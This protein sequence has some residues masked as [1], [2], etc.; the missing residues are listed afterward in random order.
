MDRV[1]AVALARLAAINPLI[2]LRELSLDFPEDVPLVVDLDGTLLS[3][4]LLLETWLLYLRTNPEKL[5]TPFLWL[6]R[7]KAFLKD[8]LARE[9]ALDV[10]ALPYNPEIVALLTA[11]RAR[12]RQVILAT[13]SHHALAERIAQH[14]GIFDGVIA[15]DRTRNLSAQSK[16]DA[17]VAR[18]GAGGFDYAGNSR[19]DLPVWEAARQAI[20]VNPEPGVEK[21][22]RELGNVSAI[23]DSKRTSVGDWARALRCHQWLKNLLIFVPLLAAHRVTE[24]D[25]LADGLL[26]FLAFGLCASTVYILNDLLDLG[27][28]RHH[29]TKCHRPFA[30]GV[31]SIKAGVTLLPLLLATAF[32]V[33]LMWLPPAFSVVLALYFGLTTAYSLILK[34]QML[35]DVIALASL[36]TLR[37]IAGAAVF[38]LQP[39]FWMLAFSMFIF[40]SLAL[41]KR[42]SELRLARANGC[43]GL[44]RG[45]GY[46]PEDLEMIASLGAAAGYM[47]V[48]VLALYINDFNTAGLYHH[49]E[50]IWPACLLL[51]F[52]ISRVWMLAHRGEM[53]DDPVI[54]AITD[55][56][57]LF[58]GMLFGLVFWGAA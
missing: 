28:D 35:V 39:T 7:G 37:I 47:S 46:H 57:S 42:F 6:T 12:G 41:V 29:P 38:G 52:W 32:T 53:H 2:R 44:S 36:Y 20:L 51:L 5:F 24:M 4:D 30:A 14:L 16:R 11:E 17:L 27:D 13:A 26:A 31:L 43:T 54:F 55:R 58:L 25:L 22:S 9:T 45:R 50:L 19:D 8:G 33:S 49:P 10:S 40:L 1:S 48:L 56:T 3:S 21:R 34:R 18:F 15:S 23:I